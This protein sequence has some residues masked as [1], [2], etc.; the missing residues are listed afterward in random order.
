[1]LGPEMMPPQP[2]P[3]PPP[4]PL[5]RGGESP[6]TDNQPRAP[7]PDANREARHPPPASINIDI[8]SNPSPGLSWQLVA[9]HKAGSLD[10]VVNQARLRNLALS[11]GILLI[12]TGSIIMFALATGRARKLARQQMEFVAGISHELRTPLAVI[13]SASYN[14]AQG[15]V[16]DP[17]RVQDYGTMIQKE[18]RR[19]TG[20]VEQ[21]LNFAG[22]QSGRK[23]YN[24]Q[25]T[26]IREVIDRARAEYAPLFDEAGWQVEYEMQDNLPTLLAD[27]QVVEVT[28]KNLLQNALKYAASGK[29]LRVSVRAGRN[30]KQREVQIT[31]AD[32]GP[33]IDARDLPR[34]FE[35][36]YRSAKVLA[37]PIPGAGLGLSIVQKHAQAHR[38]RVTVNSSNGQGAAFTLHLPALDESQNGNSAGS[39]E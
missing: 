34:L 28:I 12:L 18:A 26:Q 33:G 1:M 3:P 13:H 7:R 27:A 32:H 9:K 39:G 19:L 5:P 31:V 37:S 29:W 8:D 2:P 6:R 23:Q 36:F 30:G 22:I 4:P 38:G 16:A 14:L 24:F 25:P 15:V 20:Q 10:T 35:P 17:R 11:F 21:A